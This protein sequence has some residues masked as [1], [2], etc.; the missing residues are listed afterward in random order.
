MSLFEYLYDEKFETFQGCLQAGCNPNGIYFNCPILIWVIRFRQPKYFKEL[1]KYGVDLDIFTTSYR[2]IW[3]EIGIRPC[4]S[5]V[6]FL[7]NRHVAQFAHV[8]HACKTLIPL[9]SY[10]IKTIVKLCI[11]HELCRW[12]RHWFQGKDIRGRF[13]ITYL[14][15]KVTFTTY[16]FVKKTLDIC[17]KPEKYI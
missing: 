13:P 17:D 3:H 7:W 12:T 9:N 11:K 4:V 15:H 2:T 5:I 8:I 1:V 16:K 10:L 6:Q 14:T